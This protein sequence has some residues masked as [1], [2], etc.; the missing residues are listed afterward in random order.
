M[1]SV[2]ARMVTYIGTAAALPMLRKK[3]GA[4]PNA[5]R[6][7]GGATIPVLAIALSIALLTSASLNNLLA[8]GAALAAGALIYRFRRQPEPF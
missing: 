8:G 3:F 5:V 7:P 1:L 2:I 6:L 4:P